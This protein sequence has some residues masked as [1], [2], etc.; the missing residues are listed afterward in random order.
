M[1]AAR[2]SD[3]LG[4]VASDLERRLSGSRFSAPM[5]PA[6]DVLREAVNMARGMSTRGRRSARPTSSAR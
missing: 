2:A 5:G 1:E 6:V 3:L 4:S